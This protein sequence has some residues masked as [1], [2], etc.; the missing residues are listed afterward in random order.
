MRRGLIV[1]CLLLA[2]PSCAAAASGQG[3]LRLTGGVTVS[4]HGRAGACEEVGLCGTRGVVRWRSGVQG[5]VFYSG[6]PGHWLP[7]F[8]STFSSDQPVARVLRTGADG[9]TTACVDV[10]GSESPFDAWL[11]LIPGPGGAPRLALGSPSGEPVLRGP[12]A[13]GRSPRTSVPL[14]SAPFR[15]SAA[16]DLRGTTPF[17]AGPF[18]GSVRS[19][20]R[21]EAAPVHRERTTTTSGSSA[22]PAPGQ[23]RIVAVTALYRV[24]SASGGFRA[25]LSGD[26]ATC[27]A[28]DSC[29]A[30]GRVSVV[31][32]DLVGRRLR[33]TGYRR[34]RGGAP[35]GTA[36]GLADLR[37]GRLAALD[38]YLDGTFAHD[39]ATTVQLPGETA[40]CTDAL[41]GVLPGL[42]VGGRR[43]V[44]VAIDTR[45]SSEAGDV[46]RTRCPGPGYAA[47]VGDGPLLAGAVPVARL[48]D[49][50]TTVALTA[51]GT[52]AAG[53]WSGQR[54]GTLA[55]GLRRL[56]VRV[57]VSG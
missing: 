30:V 10:A 39:T 19:T 50:A 56:R 49:P 15:T 42:D 14:P 22:A 25:D 5:E 11:T 35:Y 34:L 38:G 36:R 55:V 26:P 40:P 23:P 48:A 51:A 6:R 1:C 32:Q 13:P 37:A 2:A 47:V 4:W 31:P 52:F 46:L 44:T 57:G 16:M 17:A 18:A 8:L 53:G 3:G 20:L 41:S 24:V 12:L 33:L 9:T 28:A 29:G 27:D 21:A 45:F 54:S 43:R 7:N